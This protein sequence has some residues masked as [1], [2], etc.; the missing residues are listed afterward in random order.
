MTDNHRGLPH[1]LPPYRPNWP[2][3]IKVRAKVVK[4]GDGWAWVHN[5][6]RRWLWQM[7]FGY[8]TQP[9]AFEAALKHAR[10]CW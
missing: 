3:P 7:A 2:L 1:D 9:E 10:G 5:C 8:P 4:G 6:P